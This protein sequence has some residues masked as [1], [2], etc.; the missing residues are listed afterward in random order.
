M[1]AVFTCCLSMRGFRSMMEGCRSLK[2]HRELEEFRGSAWMS[3]FFLKDIAGLLRL[4]PSSPSG[5]FSELF[6]SEQR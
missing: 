1:S 6:R 4:D 5:A 2:Q 3:N